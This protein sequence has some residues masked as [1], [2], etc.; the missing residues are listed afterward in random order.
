MERIGDVVEKVKD[1][2]FLFDRKIHHVVSCLVLLEES[3]VWSGVLIKG[4][5]YKA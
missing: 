1:P 4:K 2:V 3:L 5:R